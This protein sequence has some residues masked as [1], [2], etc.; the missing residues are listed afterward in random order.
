MPAAHACRLTV[1]PIVGWFKLL[2][3]FGGRVSSFASDLRCSER[4]EGG[5]KLTFELQETQV[6]QVTGIPRPPPF[7][8]A[9]L[10][11]RRFPVNFVWKLLPWNGGRA[12]TC[13]TYV[14]YCDDDLRV[15]EDSRGEIFVYT[16]AEEDAEGV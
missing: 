8:L 4:G 14:T 13:T 5:L 1:I 11:G 15:C 16:R 9:W 6:D 3:T 10:L 12:P 7:F 2:P